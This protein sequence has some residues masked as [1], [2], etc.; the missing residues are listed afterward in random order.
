[1][2]QPRNKCPSTGEAIENVHT[3]GGQSAAKMLAQHRIGGPQDEVDDLYR[4][5][6]DPQ[7]L[8]LFLE[9]DPEELLIELG[10]YLLLTFGAGDLAGAPSH[11][12]VKAFQPSGFRFQSRP[13]D[14]ID[15]FLHG[16]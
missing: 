4:R 15:H 6:D 1:M 9:T 8:G 11:R 16:L 12:F 2:Q 3:L 14:R 13:A 10:N 5:V 7:R